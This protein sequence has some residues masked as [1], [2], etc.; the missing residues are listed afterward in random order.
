MLNYT[1]KLKIF[2]FNCIEYDK[3]LLNKRNYQQNIRKVLVLCLDIFFSISTNISAFGHSMLV[4]ERPL[5]SLSSICLSACPSVRPSVTKFSQDCIIRFDS[6]IVL[7]DSWPWY[8]VTDKAR[9][10]TK[11]FT[12]RI[13]A[14]WV[15]TGPGTRFF[16][17]FSSLVY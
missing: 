6:D 4:G 2:I 12:A 17:I 1:L 8:L 9:Y 11:K 14:K 3:P 13:W 5:K 10:L 7:H 16:A 15:K